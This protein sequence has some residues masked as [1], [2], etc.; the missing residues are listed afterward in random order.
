MKFERTT[1]YTVIAVY[2]FL[3][4]VAVII[5][6]SLWAHI[7]QILTTAGRL[8]G[9]VM[10]VVYGFVLA[11]LFSPLF[12]VFDRKLL[13]KLSGT[14]KPGLRRGLALLFTYL[15]LLTVLAAALLLILPQII[16]SIQELIV[17]IARLVGDAPVWYDEI[18]Q[19]LDNFQRDANA[20]DTLRQL[21]KQALDTLEGLLA[22]VGDW[23]GT[24]VT[25]V[26]SGLTGLASGVG[27]WLLGFVLSIYILGSHESLA[28]QTRKVLRSVL[29]DKASNEIDLIARDAY[30]IFSGY[31]AGA[32]LDACILGL[33][34]FV[35]MSL[36]G[37][38]YSVLTA[39]IIGVSNMIPFFG[40]I[41]GVVVGVVLQLSVSPLNALIF[42]IYAVAMQ[43]IDANILT[44]RIVGSSVGLPPLWVIF[45]ILLFGGL[46]GVVGML[47]GVPLFALLFSLVRRGVNELLR[48]KES[49]GADPE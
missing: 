44:P 18:Y 11:F 30:R 38:S 25:G 22:G 8:I 23:L 47:I 35:V 16:A 42:L 5:F 31:L 48:R 40:P 41:F 26:L 37:L 10:P 32:A 24:L 13:P 49:A 46:L 12:R 43:Q 15:V 2:A 20:S 19:L 14:I 27:N 7:G 4:I 9:Y 1:K 17:Q 3:V 29:P 6:S 34:C 21:V 39:V 33:A 28:A 45:A 36:F